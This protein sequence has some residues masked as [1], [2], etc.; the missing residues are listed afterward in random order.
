MGELY[1]LARFPFLFG[2]ARLWRPRVAQS[3]MF[4]DMPP[5]DR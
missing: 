4:L 5:A 1:G 3:F 2:L